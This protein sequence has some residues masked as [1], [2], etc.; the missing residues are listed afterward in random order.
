MSLPEIAADYGKLQDKS[1]KVAELEKRI[2][3]LYRD[4]ETTSRKLG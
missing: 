2:R 4:W 3:D 1:E